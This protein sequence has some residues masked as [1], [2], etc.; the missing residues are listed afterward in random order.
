MKAHKPE[1]RPRFDIDALEKIAGEKVFARG[2]VYHRSGQVQLLAIEPGRVLAQV[3]GTED[4]RTELTGGGDRIGGNCSCPAFED[5]G[6]C[7]HMVAVAL[8]VN[9]ASMDAE[10][11][12]ALSRIRA[13]LTQK[14]VD[15]LVGIIMDLAERD[16]GLFRKLDMAA[17]SVDAND[18]TLRTRL[19]K[20]IDAATRTRGFVEYH[21]APG[22]AANV[23][24][25]LDAFADLAS[26]TRA[27]LAL[28]LAEHAIDRIERA[29]EEIDDSDGHCSALLERVRD[30]HFAAA[31]T[32][33]PESMQFA[34][35]LFAREVNGSY[36]TF[37]GAVALYAEILGEE[38][39]AEYH[40]LAAEAWEKLSRH[41]AGSHDDDDLPDDRALRD[42]L[43]FFAE[44]AGDVD[45]RI[46]LRSRD[47]SS[48]WHYL[49]LAQFCLAQGRRDE[50]LRRAEEGLWVFEDGR[51]DERLVS[52]TAGLLSDA[53]RREEAEAHLWRAFEKAPSLGLYAQLRQ[54]GGA[55][56]LQRVTR[57]LEARIVLNERAHWSAPANLLADILMEEKMFDE[58]WAV[59]GKHRT[60]VGARQALA[61]LSEATHPREALEVYAEQVDQFVGT[62]SN[63]AYAEAV[64]LIARMAGLRSAAEHT[65]YVA[66]FKERY[67]RKRNLMKLLG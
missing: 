50:A 44:R 32:A 14:S 62:G 63:S 13:H 48:P 18:K 17:A 35:D 52:F 19:C 66:A 12:G 34:R 26:G 8:A 42:I 4:Y 15:A 53:G 9:A 10:G 58:A 2:E 45:A 25:A 49:E 21:E 47:L 29:I 27:N 24:A 64:K 5:W 55:S 67:G 3:E 43:D 38:G 56:V 59:V 11:M 7:K 46:A 22:W 57:I 31:E 65:A 16:L 51:L 23:D 28:E 36:G 39:L 6:V 33:Q 1:H 20:T 30:I 54:L 41:K 37:S 40:R 61:R 60:A